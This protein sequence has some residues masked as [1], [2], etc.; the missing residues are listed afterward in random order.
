MRVL[1]RQ[2]SASRENEDVVT[3]AYVAAQRS[4]DS[5]I[6]EAKTD[7]QRILDDARGSVTEIEAQAAEIIGDS[8]VDGARFHGKIV[9]YASKATPAV[10]AALAGRAAAMGV[11]Y[12]IG[13]TAA[14]GVVISARQHYR[15]DS[16]AWQQELAEAMESLG[17]ARPTA[18]IVASALA[19]SVSAR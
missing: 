3:K 15:M 8:T 6:E 14:Y 1:E 19:R 17:P 13:I 12:A 11:P 10:A 5:I 7:A 9:P 2:L 4:A 18:V 16:D